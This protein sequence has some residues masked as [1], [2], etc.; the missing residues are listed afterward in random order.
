[1][2]AHLWRASSTWRSSRSCHTSVEN[3]R[4]SLSTMCGRTTEKTRSTTN[5][6]TPHSII[7]V[8]IW[9]DHVSDVSAAG[10][11]STWLVSSR[12]SSGPKPNSDVFKWSCQSFRTIDDFLGVWRHRGSPVQS[13]WVTSRCDCGAEPLTGTPNLE[14]SLAACLGRQSCP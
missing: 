10:P 14:R 4:K 12:S 11:T 1:M 9:E 5:G 13:R 2:Q 7:V 3:V 8:A 6:R